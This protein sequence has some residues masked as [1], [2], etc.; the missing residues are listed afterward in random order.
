MKLKNIFGVF[1]FFLL[2][3]CF[4]SCAEK[5]PEIYG[6][7]SGFLGLVKNNVLNIYKFTGEWTEIPDRRFTLSPGD[8]L[9]YFD[10]SFIIIQKK[11]VLK[12][13]TYN[14]GWKETEGSFTLPAERGE[15]LYDRNGSDIYIVMRNAIKAISFNYS[16]WDERLVNNID[17]PQKRNGIF[18]FSWLGAAF[19][20]VDGKDSLQ[21]FELNGSVSSVVI[22]SFTP[23]RGYKK[24]VPYY[25]CIGIAEN[26]EINFYEPG[27]DN[28][29]NQKW[30]EIPEM[31][32][33]ING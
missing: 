32:F 4:L 23:P 6:S 5:R 30:L 11:N 26:D 1:I 16:H 29:G 20:C 9:I 28:K 27:F 12:L 18:L 8:K 19:I 10:A 17:L 31:R 3:F 33:F 25:Q 21:F 14:A 13:Q 15:I 7:N 2:S 22:S 24:A